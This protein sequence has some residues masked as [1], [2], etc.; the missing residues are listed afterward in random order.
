MYDID[1]MSTKD[2]EN[3]FQWYATMMGELDF[4][5]EK[6]AYCVSDVDILRHLLLST[7]GEQ[8]PEN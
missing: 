1:S 3:F 4:R 2:G 7:M 5:K 6:Q 8:F